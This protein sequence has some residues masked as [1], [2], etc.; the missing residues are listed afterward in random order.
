MKLVLPLLLALSAAAHAAGGEVRPAEGSPEPR[1]VP[2]L[3]L[4]K[5]ADQGM[6][7]ACTV[8]V[9]TE[10]K[11]RVTVTAVRGCDGVTA[12]LAR[13]R[14]ARIKLAKD[15]P[16]GTAATYEIAWPDALAAAEFDAPAFYRWREGR[17]CEV[18]L[19]VDAEGAV[20][21]TDAQDKSG[22]PLG[23]APDVRDVTAPARMARPVR[24][25]PLLCSV[26]FTVHDGAPG[27]L[28]IF[29]C[30]LPLRPT[31]RAVMAAA[32][33]PV[34]RHPSPVSL[35]IAVDRTR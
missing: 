8:E 29:R 7:R 33:W 26:T 31:A 12:E 34:P 11:G 35:L 17:V 10:D 19:R 6:P 2:W 27:P 24:R 15:T 22:L 30:P 18:R 20:R 4:P 14:A 3:P 1:S 21:V 9:L 25:V 28:S 16:V 23:C 32:E 5:E 13:K